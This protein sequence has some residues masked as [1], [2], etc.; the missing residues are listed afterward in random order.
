VKPV[1]ETD[2]AEHADWE[3]GKRLMR[4]DL[5][6]PNRRII[7]VDLRNARGGAEDDCS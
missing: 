3:R 1:I 2:D 7:T 4:S 5:D 6:A